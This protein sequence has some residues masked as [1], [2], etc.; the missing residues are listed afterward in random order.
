VSAGP[1]WGGGRRGRPE[2]RERAA[3]P[4]QDKSEKNDDAPAAAEKAGTGTLNINSLPASRVLVD[5]TP[6]GST[7]KVDY[8]ISAG[9]HT[10]TFVHPDLG[11]KSI[12]VNVKPG[13][14]SVAAVRFKAPSSDE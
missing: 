6:I 9:T 13:Q 14:A 5:G 4:D 7:P 3:P 12:S 10:I 1:A 8:Q 11:K 2:P